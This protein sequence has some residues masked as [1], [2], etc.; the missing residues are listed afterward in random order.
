MPPK[1][2]I[3]REEILRSAYELALQEGYTSISSRNVARAAGCS[4]QPVFSHFPTMEILR[5]ETY[6]YACK[7][8]AEEVLNND[9]AEIILDILTHWMLDLAKNRPNLFELLYLSNLDAASFVHPQIMQ[10]ENHLKMR[11]TIAATYDLSPEA[12]EDL[13]IRSCIFLMGIGTMICINKVDVA[14]E[15]ALKLMHATVHDFIAGEH[16][17]DAKKL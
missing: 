7:V 16:R 8:C 9:G 15:D 3:T 17:A 5:R 12:S 14:E 6:Q 10:A 13:L 11:E 1:Q 2:K 4:V